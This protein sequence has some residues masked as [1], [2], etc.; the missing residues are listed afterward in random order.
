VVSYQTPKGGVLDGSQASETDIC[1][2][3]FGDVSGPHRRRAG[4]GMEVRRFKHVAIK[5]LVMKI[6]DIGEENPDLPTLETLSSRSNSPVPHP[7]VQFSTLTSIEEG[8]SSPPSESSSQKPVP[9]STLPATHPSV[10]I[11]VCIHIYIYIYVY[12]YMYIYI[13]IYKYIYVYIYICI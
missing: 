3:T 1:D 6:V 9:F 8:D 12:V 4:S 11:S 13:Y 7:K 2:V 10:Y 5:R